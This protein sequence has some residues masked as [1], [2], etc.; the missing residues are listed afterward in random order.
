MKRIQHITL[1][2]IYIFIVTSCTKEIEFNGEILDR[3]LVVNAICPLDSTFIVEVS[4][5]K[6]IPGYESSFR[7]ITD[8]TVKLYVD[9]LETEKLEYDSS[10]KTFEGLFSYAQSA[11][12]TGKTVIESGKNYSIVVIHPDYKT[13]AK[14]EMKIGKRVPILNIGTDS[15]PYLDNL[16]RNRQK[17]KVN[18]KFSDPVDEENFYRLV[19]N[20]R[21][22]KGFSRED[23]HGETFYHVMV[24]DYVYVYSTIESDDP[25]FSSKEDADEILFGS[26]NRS[27]L[28]LFTDE[29]FNGKTYDLSFYLNE[30]IFYS[31]QEEGMNTTL[32]DFY[33]VTIELQ[34]LTKD[35]YYYIKS[36]GSF[37][38]VSDGL[39]TEPVQVYNDIEN[40]MG[41]F[42]GCS[43][44]ISIIQKGEY[45]IEGYEYSY[46]S[47]SY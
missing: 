16:S 22:G 33:I 26:T 11:F 41:I 46:S 37:D 29:L 28:T 15:I 35:S 23:S 47:S 32:G 5:S 25:V 27:G 20:Y 36:V 40:G 12:Y 42:G 19:I 39:F 7:M 1:F 3:K 14:G 24:T 38:W 18:M 30:N 44:S 6:P 4:E 8:A 31:F 45:P 9:G 13:Y 43:S 2:I 34:S 17:T 21:L 10:G